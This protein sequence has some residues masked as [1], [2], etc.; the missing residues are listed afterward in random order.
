MPLRWSPFTPASM[1]WPKAPGADGAHRRPCPE[2]GRWR[3]ED[4]E[5]CGTLTIERWITRNERDRALADFEH[6]AREHERVRANLQ[7]VHASLAACERQRDE[8]IA[9]L[10][11]MPWSNEV[12]ATLGRS[13]TGR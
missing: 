6:L 3:D 8:A 10:M 12:I 5:I 9:V 13:S 7:A 2:C 1:G 11:C 4:D